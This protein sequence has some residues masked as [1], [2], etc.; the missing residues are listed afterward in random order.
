MWRTS[1][2]RTTRRSEVGRLSRYSASLVR[3]RVRVRV[4][5]RVRV[6]VRARVGQG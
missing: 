5:F 2:W 1:R 6:R 3:V 4:R